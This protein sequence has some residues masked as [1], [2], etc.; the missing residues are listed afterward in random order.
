MDLQNARK[1]ARQ[2]QH[3]MIYLITKT[4]QKIKNGAR[5]KEL[6]PIR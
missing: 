6:Y 4:Q 1:G 3:D 2:V 5:Q